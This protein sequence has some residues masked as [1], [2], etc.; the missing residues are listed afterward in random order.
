VGSKQGGRRA[1]ILFS[2]VQ[3]CKRFE[4][5]PWAYLKDLFNKLPLLGERPAVA[6]LDRST[7]GRSIKFAAK[8][9]KNAVIEIK[10]P[11]LPKIF[12]YMTGRILTSQLT[13]NLTAPNAQCILKSFL[14]KYPMHTSRLFA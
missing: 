3:T 14:L 11:D 10:P 1:A 5:E 6:E 4:V 2:L 12:V 7:F 8:K 13:W 9:I